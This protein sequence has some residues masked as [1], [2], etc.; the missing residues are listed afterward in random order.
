[1]GITCRISLRTVWHGIKRILRGG[2]S[3]RA[4][5]EGGKTLGRKTRTRE[6][7]D[8]PRTTTA[9]GKEEEPFL[10]FL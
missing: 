2:A 10:R 5:E 1:M 8:S 4:R 7:S 9:K 6:E 3:L